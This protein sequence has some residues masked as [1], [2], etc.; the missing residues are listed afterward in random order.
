MVET[1]IDAARFSAVW[2]RVSQKEDDESA[3]CRL[4]EGEKQTTAY[5][6]ALSKRCSGQ[7]RQALLRMAADEQRHMRL[8]QTELFLLRGE[9]HLPPDS[10]APGDGLL[11]ACRLAWQGEKETEADYLRAAQTT[12]RPELAEL[13][14][15]IAP[16]E[17]KHAKILRQLIAKSML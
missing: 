8:L 5:Y 10:T 4:I 13:Y 11:S 12:G 15:Q 14:R 2:E 6:R 16:E 17:A 3:L 9:L 1:S 7:I